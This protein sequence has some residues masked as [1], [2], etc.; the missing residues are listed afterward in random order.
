M[1]LWEIR[2]S[3]VVQKILEQKKAKM[4]SSLDDLRKTSKNS[5]GMKLYEMNYMDVEASE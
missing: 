1:L 2:L 3:K 4:L 5:T